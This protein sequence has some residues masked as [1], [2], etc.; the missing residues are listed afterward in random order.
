MLKDWWD[1]AA[2]VLWQVLKWTAI[3]AFAIALGITLAVKQIAGRKG[4]D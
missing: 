1:D 2:P 3:V 4:F